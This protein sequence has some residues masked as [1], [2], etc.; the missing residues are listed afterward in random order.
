MPLPILAEGLWKGLSSIPYGYTLLKAASWVLV[1]SLLKYYFGGAR[2]SSERV[3]HSKVVIVTV[4][5]YHHGEEQAW[6]L[7]GS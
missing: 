2:N 4:S 1:I 5:F 7:R 6:S 3:M